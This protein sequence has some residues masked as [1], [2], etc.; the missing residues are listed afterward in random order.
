[1]KLPIYLDYHATTPVDPRVLEIMLPYFTENF[2]NPASLNHSFGWVA[3]S[4]VEKAR[5]QVAQLIGATPQEIFFTSGATESINLALKGV[6]E[7][8]V[9][10]GKHIITAVTEHKA[11]IDSCKHLEKQGWK[12]TYLP[13]NR[14]GLLDLDQLRDSITTETILVSVMHANNEIGTVQDVKGIGEICRERNVFFHTDATQA[15]GR[16]HFNV[17]AL[18]VDIAA[19][20]S[21]KIY[22]PKGVG[23]IYIRKHHPRVQIVPQIDGGGQEHNIRSGTTNVAG[24][25]GFGAACELYSQEWGTETERVKALRDKLQHALF[26]ELTDVH[27]NGHPASRLPNNLHLSFPGISSELLLRGIKD[28]AVST[29]A[30]CHSETMTISY[31]L[32]AIGLPIDLAKSSIR[33]GL[34]RFSTEEEIDFAAEHI[35]HAVKKIRAERSGE[36]AASKKKIIT[37]EQQH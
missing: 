6:A 2:G 31:V 18:N 22:G 1:M 10:K 19:C 8:Y 28:I 11:V 32:K 25:V 36:V 37:S 17:D 5:E 34:G 16:L 24:I 9:S 26:Q 13:V 30:A 33:I 12:I 14:E 35:I 7:A 27:L 3:S 4:A 15:I 23:A 29:G 20:S 21:H